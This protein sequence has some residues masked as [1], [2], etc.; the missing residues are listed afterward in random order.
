MMRSWNGIFITIVSSHEA[1]ATKQKMVSRST[2]YLVASGIVHAVKCGYKTFHARTSVQRRRRG[3][4]RINALERQLTIAKAKAR[5]KEREPKKL[6]LHLSSYINEDQF[7]SLHRSPRGT[8]WSKETLTKA[9]KIR[10]SCG[11]RGYDMVKELGQPLP[12][13]RTLQR[14]IEHCKFRPGLLVDIMD[15]L[16][17]KV[18]CMTEY[19]R[20]VCLMMNEMQITPSLIYD[21]S[22]DAVLGRPTIPLAD[23]SLPA[24][25]L[26]THGLVFMLGGVTTRTNAPSSVLVLTLLASPQLSVHFHV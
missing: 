16:A 17:V 11:S 3:F 4:A 13:Q 1:A 21:P 5:V 26:A 7:T 2:T 15:S 8:V 19:E 20:H 18:I 10:L 14:H 9:L 25:T 6:M 24:D 22:A 23:G 12:S